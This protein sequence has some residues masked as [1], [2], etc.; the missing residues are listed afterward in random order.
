M[1]SFQTSIES[2]SIIVAPNQ[3]RKLSMTMTST[4][5][6]YCQT[7]VHRRR[8]GLR[9]NQDNYNVGSRNQRILLYDWIANNGW[10][11]SESRLRLDR[12][13][14]SICRENDIVF[15]AHCDILCGENIE[16]F[17]DRDGKKTCFAP[18]TRAW[19]RDWSRQHVS[20]LLDLLLS[21]RHRLHR[22]FMTYAKSILLLLVK[23]EFSPVQRQVGQRSP[24]LECVPIP[25]WCG[26][27]KGQKHQWKWIPLAT[28]FPRNVF[29]RDGIGMHSLMVRKMYECMTNRSR[30]HPWPSSPCESFR[31]LSS[32]HH[33]H[34]H[35][36]QQ[37]YG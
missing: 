35:R 25:L 20:G 3:V 18:R 31:F 24:S 16:L 32:R 28:I 10:G 17:E 37:S 4:Q 26:M 7:H 8:L 34:H 11:L 2:K 29:D 36:Q 15:Q 5:L 13:E 19:K 21:R 14:Y 33:H 30:V 1:Q 23:P 9:L 12:R 22:T 6:L 27:T